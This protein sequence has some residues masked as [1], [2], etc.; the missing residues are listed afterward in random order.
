MMGILD[1][2]TGARMGRWQALAF[3]EFENFV[4]F[5]VSSVTQFVEAGVECFFRVFCLRLVNHLKE[6]DPIQV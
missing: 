3:T 6:V 4:I 1:G 2:K 5:R